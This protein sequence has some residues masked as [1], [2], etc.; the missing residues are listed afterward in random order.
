MKKLYII[1]AHRAGKT[2]L[3]EN[4]AAT[5]PDVHFAR[6]GLKRVF[7]PVWGEIKDA[8]S[9]GDRR[10]FYAL[11]VELQRMLARTVIEDVASIPGDAEKVVLDRSIIDVLAYSTNYLETCVGFVG[12]LG[13][14]FD[15]ID[16]FYSMVWGEIVPL[17]D[18]KSKYMVIQPGIGFVPVDG[19][20]DEESQKKTS[21]NMIKWATRLIPS[22]NLVIIPDST[23]NLKERMAYATELLN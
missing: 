9:T 1:G 19:S 21:A 12:K 3:C 14:T 4:L 7:K 8:L 20:L 5:Y 17:V 13:L 18:T 10:R 16:D 6:T 11:V 23:T 22:E 15:H 2:Y